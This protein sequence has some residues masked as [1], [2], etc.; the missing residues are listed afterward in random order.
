MLTVQPGFWDNPREAEAIMQAIRSKKLW[1]DQFEKISTGYDDLET[2]N[3]FY[4]MGEVEAEEIDSEYK[5]L[6]SANI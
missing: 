5:S 4:E 3:E 6:L 2:L 1:T